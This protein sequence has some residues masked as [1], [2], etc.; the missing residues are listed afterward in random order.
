MRLC[1]GHPLTFIRHRF[2]KNFTG[3]NSVVN[4]CAVNEDHVAVSCGD[5]GSIHFW[6][7]DTG[8]CFQQTQ[9]IVQPGSLDAES[10]IF[11]CAFDLSGSRL[12]TCEADKTIKIWKENE[13][14]T[15]ETHPVDMQEWS[16]QCLALKR[17]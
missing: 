7:Y 11:A 8:Y 6:D 9:T 4:C 17:Y 2:L 13:D 3:H 15:E 5:N 14:A 10:G 12:V 1:G 16:R